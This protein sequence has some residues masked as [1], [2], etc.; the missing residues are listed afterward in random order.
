[1]EV[2]GFEQV[3]KIPVPAES[4]FRTRNAIKSGGRFAI[5]QC[6]AKSL[7]VNVIAMSRQGCILLEIIILIK[8]ERN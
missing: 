5:T 4:D 2:E 6:K 7:Q 8:L 3:E 1:M